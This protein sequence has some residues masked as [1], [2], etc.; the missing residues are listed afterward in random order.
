M[1]IVKTLPPPHTHTLPRPHHR[2]R[3]PPPIPRFRV[4]GR[5]SALPE[6]ACLLLT[7]E[8]LEVVLQ[9]HRRGVV[10]MDLKPVGVGACHRPD[11]PGAS[12]CM[13]WAGGCTAKGAAALLAWRCWR[14]A[15]RA[16]LWAVTDNAGCTAVCPCRQD[17]LL[18]DVEGLADSWEQ[19]CDPRL[20]PPCRPPPPP[21][22]LGLL[23]LG[24]LAPPPHHRRPN[25]LHW[26]S[27]R[28]PAPV[29]LAALGV[30]LK[31]I[32]VC[33]SCACALCPDC[34]PLGP[35]STP[36]ARAGPAPQPSP[37]F[38][39]PSTLGTRCSRR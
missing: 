19:R 16:A 37:P 3:R 6:G 30:K 1:Q 24:F 39:C 15:R 31:L 10:H 18:F 21:V 23:A 27:L 26:A 17:N 34:T 13:G 12:A 35:A 33:V 9:L 11:A 25:S 22:A 4:L 8:M 5:T 28:H 32:L 36:T 14:G 38:W 29:P 2:T 20:P 7:L